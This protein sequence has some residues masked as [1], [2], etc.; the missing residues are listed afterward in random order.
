MLSNLGF[1]QSTHLYLKAPFD[2]A[3][4]SINQDSVR[5]SWN[6]INAASYEVQ[7]SSDPGFGTF[8]SYISTTGEG[9]IQQSD[10]SVASYWRV[11]AISGEIS[12]VRSFTLINLGSLGSLVY[13]IHAEAG[14]NI[15]SNK[16]ANWDNLASINHNATQGLSSARPTWKNDEIN[17]HSTVHF[18]GTNGTSQHNLT[19]SPL[20]IEQ[21]NF[22]VFVT[23]KQETVNNALPYLLG[24]QGG[25]RIGGIH[26]RGTAGTF[27]NF[28]AI[29]DSPLVE[30]R[31]NFSGNLN[32]GTR[33]IVNNQIYFNSS[34]VAGYTGAGV[35]G[36]R[37]SAIGAR[38]DL[39]ALNFHG[40]LAEV[41]IYSNS[42]NTINR[43][44]VED[45]LLTKYTPYPDL[46]EDINVCDNSVVLGPISDPAFNT[47]LWSTGQSGDE[48]IQ[49]IENGWYWVETE[50]FGRI[51]R[52]SIH[53]SG[54]VPVPQLTVLNDTT[55]CYGDTVFL[56]Y[57]NTLEPGVSVEWL[58]GST[59]PTIDVGDVGTYSLTF[60]DGVGC[61]FSSTPVTFSVN[62]FPLTKGLGTDRIFCL[63]TALFFEYGTAGLAPY[64]HVWSDGSTGSSITPQVLGF[65]TFNVTV[66][67]AIGCVAQDTIE[68]ELIGTEG[69]TMD[70]DFD[71]VCHNTP[72]TFT[73]LSI[74]A[75]GDNITVQS[76]L[77]PDDT[78]TGASVI[79]QSAVNST[80][81]VDLLVETA[82][83]CK[84]RI[85][86]TISFRPQPDTYF[87]PGNFCQE[88]SGSFLASQLSPENIV[89]WEWDFDDP[90]SGANNTASGAAVSH[91]FNLS[92]NYNVQLVATDIN[93][94][95]DTV[96]Q[97]VNVKTAPLVDFEF[98]EACAGD[99]VT[100]T[101]NTS[102]DA[103][104]VISGYTWQFGDGSSSGQTNPMK[105]Y[106]NAGNYSVTLLAT[107]NNGCTGSAS[108]TVKAHAIPQPDYLSSLG[109][110]GSSIF[111]EDNSFVLNGSVATVDWSFNDSDPIQ[112]F[113]VN[114][115]FE[116][117]GS[118]NIE[119]TV[120]SAFG[121][122]G[123]ATHTVSLT[124]FLFADFSISPG[125][126]LA[127]YSMSFE[128]ESVGH[129]NTTWI[130]N[131]NDTVSSNS[132][133]WTF[134]ENQVGEEVE[135]ILIVSNDAGCS[136]TIVRYFT[137]LE[138][139][140]DLAVNQLFVQD[141]SGFYIVGTQLENRGSTP[142]TGADLFLRST[143]TSIIKEE[144]SG[145]LEAGE[146][147]I[148]VF[149]VQVPST[150][151]SEVELENFICVEAKLT[152]PIGFE[153]EELSN[154]EKCYSKDGNE[155][156]LLIPYPNPTN[157]L[158]NLR[159]ILPE[160]TEASIQIYDAT[161]KLVS[162]VTEN[163][164]LS[165]GL[166]TFSVDASTWTN[167]I[168]SII[169]VAGKDKKT[170]KIQVLHRD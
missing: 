17:G 52:D 25:G 34:E 168:Y 154:N 38:P 91:T 53:V 12:A 11:V 31:P 29:Y 89:S 153:D 37:F 104:F 35:D 94:C 23:V 22:S 74:A 101:N 82:A 158:F 100:F 106:F 92:G 50:A 5:F 49:V 81:F 156:I 59:T 36:L 42:L 69:P 14:L 121:C 9:W 62:E 13:H 7:L 170:G 77:F 120:M 32:W 160:E 111:F 1:S 86:D 167:G 76:W 125:A 71:T 48:T 152:A 83:G 75:G 3:V 63:N 67:D 163:S 149:T 107:A 119:Q 85:R 4:F 79:Y 139:R 93:G 73:D 15:I 66:T 10:L 99:F 146:K 112:G 45:Y 116:S 161:G 105:P 110:A 41:I 157:D 18:G 159:V 65:E 144:W 148:Y 133:N 24:Y 55:I 113:E 33:S 84:G 138:N 135:I 6:Q 98:I 137:V 130:V 64:T 70:F 47:I 97:V 19:L 87:V 166:T 147:E 122:I 102:I 127:G 72:N 44:L 142:I 43:E 109:C 27:N 169:L 140:T 108:K 128:N 58:D 30:R 60:T 39:P 126:I 8:E 143:N 132:F 150:V 129:D 114:Y 118:Q 145:L 2:E 165:K 61:S 78:L 131:E 46:G 90:A 57:T 68:I 20:L 155:S 40:D 56:G 117:I 96:V 115:I 28:G 16:V 134:S 95:T 26:L 80:Y 54:L 21:P 123:E 141:A 51:M 164:P 88:V 103:P 124:D 151:S 136:D 162:T